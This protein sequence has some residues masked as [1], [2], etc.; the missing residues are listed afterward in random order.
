MP[1]DRRPGGSPPAAGPGRIRPSRQTP[2]RRPRRRSR[3]PPRALRPRS[4]AS[5]VTPAAVPQSS[6]LVRVLEP[7]SRS[8]SGQTR[9]VAK[10]QLRDLRQRVPRA[11]KAIIGV[12]FRQT[13]VRNSSPSGISPRSRPDRRH[14]LCRLSTTVFGVA[15]AHR[16]AHARMTLAERARMRNRRCALSATMRKVP[17]RKAGFPTK[18][19]TPALRR[20]TAAASRPAALPPP[21]SE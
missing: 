11:T 14:R 5:S 13:R 10:A 15:R 21:G 20:Q 9:Q 12:A 18:V 7:R 3:A 8:T 6:S 17:D 1:V 19:P 2:P 16:Y 4:A